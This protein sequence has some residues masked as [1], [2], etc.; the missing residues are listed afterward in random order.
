MRKAAVAVERAETGLESRLTRRTSLLASLSGALRGPLAPAPLPAL[1]ALAAT[2]TSPDPGAEAV[3]DDDLTARALGEVGALIRARAGLEQAAVRASAAA[4]AARTRHRSAQAAERKAEE[5]QATARTQ[6]RRARDPLVDLGAPQA[7]DDSLAE[8]WARLSEWAAG[9][10]RAR[11]AAL[12]EA[13]QAAQQDDGRHQQATAGF[14]TA[15]QALTRLRGEA[16]T[17]A[18]QDQQAGARLAQVTARVA[19]LDELL[20]DAPG[21]DQVTAQ[22][23]LRDELEAAA[24]TAGQALQGARTAR[25]SGEAALAGL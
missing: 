3:P 13:R 1:A 7:D 10:A 4:D 25:A 19:D 9:Q 18:T 6:L 15:E 21:E 12:A 2:A 14:R 17:A 5:D 11:A 23:A 20:R 24:A 8:G 22:L 16:K